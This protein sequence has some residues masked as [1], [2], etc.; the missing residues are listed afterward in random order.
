MTK[1]EFK[2]I[3]EELDAKVQNYLFILGFSD[4]YDCF[5]AEQSIY[6]YAFCNG[7]GFDTVDDLIHRRKTADQLVEEYEEYNEYED[8]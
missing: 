5:F 4:V 2:E 6:N 3:I 7:I 1:E 8:D